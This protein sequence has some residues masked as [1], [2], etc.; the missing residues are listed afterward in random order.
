[1]LAA[2]L[3]DK[4]FLRHYLN[5]LLII[6]LNMGLSLKAARNTPCKAQEHLPDF[7]CIGEL[8]P[9][10]IFDIQSATCTK[11]FSAQNS[12]L[13]PIAKL[14]TLHRFIVWQ[15]RPIKQ[16]RT[17]ESEDHIPISLDFRDHNALPSAAVGQLHWLQ[18]F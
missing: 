14:E 7:L 11:T 15:E 13:Q 16:F 8:Q 12:P 2:L 6:C 5:E 10:E 18:D 17:D 4:N 1:M 3:V 9:V